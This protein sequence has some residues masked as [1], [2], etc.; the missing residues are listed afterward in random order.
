MPRTSPNDFVDSDDDEQLPDEQPFDF[1]GSSPASSES[2]RHS[3]DIGPTSPSLRLKSPSPEDDVDPLIEAK[4]ELQRL[5]DKKAL[6]PYSEIRTQ[7]KDPRAKFRTAVKQA[8]H[9]GMKEGSA[10]SG[11]KSEFARVQSPGGTWRKPTKLDKVEKKKVMYLCVKC[12]DMKDTLENSHVGYKNDELANMVFKDHPN[13][14][15][16]SEMLKHL[17]NKHEELN[18]EIAFVCKPCGKKLEPSKYAQGPTGQRHMNDF[19]QGSAPSNEGRDSES[20]SDCEST[21]SSVSLW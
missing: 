4:K 11:A 6:K 5:R 2:E 18:V 14:Q 1:N 17:E 21:S 9:N 8:V 20:E 10:C 12:G 16:F 3:A 13:E 15:R 19:F 7:I